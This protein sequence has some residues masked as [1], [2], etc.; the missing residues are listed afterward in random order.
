MGIKFSGHGAGQVFPVQWYRGKGFE[1]A[2]RGV[3][4]LGTTET[5]AAGTAGGSRQQWGRHVSNIF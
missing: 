5:A 4:R 3:L 2:G 1:P